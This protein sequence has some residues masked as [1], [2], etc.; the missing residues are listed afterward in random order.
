VTGVD[1]DFFQILSDWILGMMEMDRYDLFHHGHLSHVSQL[2]NL[3]G[4]E[5]INHTDHAVRKTPHVSFEKGAA[6]RIVQI[7]DRQDEESQALSLGIH[8]TLCVAP[9][10]HVRR[11]G[12]LV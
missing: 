11:C 12:R 4:E 5:S 10:R 9:S 8:S 1:G 6:W 3:V 2:A 7:D